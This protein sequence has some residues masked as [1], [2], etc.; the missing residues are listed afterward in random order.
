MATLEMAQAI[1][2]Q[3]TK[4]GL[5]LQ[6]RASEPTQP[7]PDGSPSWGLKLLAMDIADIAIV[8]P[9]P[10]DQPLGPKSTTAM[11]LCPSLASLIQLKQVLVATCQGHPASYAEYSQVTGL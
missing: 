1:A 6:S 4:D 10:G 2:S 5:L 3:G 7:V 9:L 8:F 11:A